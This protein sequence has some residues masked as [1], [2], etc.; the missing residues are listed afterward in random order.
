M[1]WVGT[2]M[3]GTGVNACC[4]K[5]IQIES[6]RAMQRTFGFETRV[7]EVCSFGVRFAN[8]QFRFLYDAC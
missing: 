6:W 7:C 1:D 3:A 2:A 5:D 4:I 8:L